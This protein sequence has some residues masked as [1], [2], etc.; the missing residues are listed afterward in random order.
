LDCGENVTTHCFCLS[1]A[2]AYNSA[3]G[4]QPFLDQISRLQ[5]AATNSRHSKKISLQHYC[6]EDNKICTKPWL[7]ELQGYKENSC[8]NS[9]GGEISGK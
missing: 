8:T 9:G 2:L 6:A 5:H 3:R 7:Q 4:V 1:V